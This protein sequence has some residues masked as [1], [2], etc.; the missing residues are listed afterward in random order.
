MQKQAHAPQSHM[1]LNCSF[2][3][4]TLLGETKAALVY[5]RVGEDRGTQMGSVILHCSII[6]RGGFSRKSLMQAK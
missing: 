6:V 1:R 3:S 4:E 5:Y 2:V